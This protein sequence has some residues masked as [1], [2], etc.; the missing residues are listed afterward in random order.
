[1]KE[2][3]IYIKNSSFIEVQTKRYFSEE[4]FK[5]FVRNGI[6]KISNQECAFFSLFQKNFVAIASKKFFL[7]KNY[8]KK[9]QNSNLPCLNC[10]VEYDCRPQNI[11]N[12]FDCYYLKFWKNQKLL[13][14][15]KIH[16]FVQKEK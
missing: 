6:M 16:F 9:N 14:R 13:G 2:L 4:L 1:M 5:T 15:N 10:P 11:I 3:K 7:N 8:V 12:L